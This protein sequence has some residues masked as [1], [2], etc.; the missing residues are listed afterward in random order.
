MLHLNSAKRC[1]SAPWS[2]AAVRCRLADRSTSLDVEMESVNGQRSALITPWQRLNNCCCRRWLYSDLL[3]L[4]GA[5]AGESK[6][7]SASD[8]R[9]AR[10]RTCLKELKSGACTLDDGVTPDCAPP[11]TAGY[12]VSHCCQL[13]WG[14]RAGALIPARYSAWLRVAGA[15]KLAA[16]PSNSCSF[17]SLA[18]SQSLPSNL[19]L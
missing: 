4:F 15:Q 11:S 3:G 13:T 17:S 12:A 19:K 7:D 10:L 8:W 9:I 2:A 5:S 16:A 18:V 14:F 6:R 1:S